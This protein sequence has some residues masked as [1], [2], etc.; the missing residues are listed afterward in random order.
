MGRCPTALVGLITCIWS[1]TD[2]NPQNCHLYPFIAD[3]TCIQVFRYLG[4]FT[5]RIAILYRFLSVLSIN[6]PV[7]CRITYKIKSNNLQ[8][9]SNIIFINLPL[10]AF[11]LSINYRGHINLMILHVR[12]SLMENCWLYFT[13]MHNHSKKVKCIISITSG[14]KNWFSE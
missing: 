6:W 8:Q 7:N 9:I 4:I 13:I 3:L 2:F 12:T 11:L 1:F 10:H 5:H 14:S